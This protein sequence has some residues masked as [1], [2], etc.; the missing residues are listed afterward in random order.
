MPV[1]FLI[2]K[3]RHL[4]PTKMGTGNELGGGM[5]WK[6]VIQMYCMKKFFSMAEEY[7]NNSKIHYFH[8]L[9]YN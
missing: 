1:Y 9:V 4:Y 2:R 8:Y 3:E 6:H 5:G 7:K